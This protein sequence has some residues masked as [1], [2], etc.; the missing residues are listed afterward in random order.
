MSAPRVHQIFVGGREVLV[1]TRPAVERPFLLFPSIGEYLAYDDGAYDRFEADGWRNAA[2]R[3]A[4]RAA[5]PE[6][7]V[8]DIGTGRDALW[9]ITAARAGARKV[10]AI[11]ALSEVAACARDAVARAGVAELVTVITGRSQDV[12]LPERAD[13]C[14]SEI[15]GNIGSAEGVN[16]VLADA[17]S[18]L[19][20][21]AASPSRTV[22]K[23]SPPQSP[24][25]SS[26]TP[27]NSPSQRRRCHTFNARSI[28]QAV[29][30]TSGCAFPARWRK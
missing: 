23:P 4:I 5:S 28:G 30:S 14:V 29:H 2:Y 21:P 12:G 25:R 7:C 17:W 3:D 22:V 11:E 27:P 15:I 18:R 24:C 16:A 10:Y 26:E 13:V 9:A 8:V 20:N 1:K 6:R 19:C